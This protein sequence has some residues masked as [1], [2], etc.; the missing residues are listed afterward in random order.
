[1]PVEEVYRR[2]CAE[3][4]GSLEKGKLLR[5]SLAP[6]YESPQGRRTAMSGPTGSA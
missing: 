2:F 6:Q 5:Q 3:N 1:M 4:G